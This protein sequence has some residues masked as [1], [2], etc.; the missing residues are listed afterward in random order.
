MKRQ[1]V[2][3]ILVTTVLLS[4]LVAFAQSPVETRNS[5][6]TTA[7]R[8]QRADYE[9]DRAAL[10]R[11][12]EELTPLRSLTNDPQLGSRVRYWQ[13]FALWRKAINGFNEPAAAP[14]ELEADLQQAVREFEEALR[15]DPAFVDARVGIISCAGYLLYLQREDPARVQELVSG[16]VQMLKDALAAAPEN[17]RVLW[18]QGP[19]L[20]YARPGLSKSEVAAR[21]ALALAAYEKGL[22]LA[23]RQRGTVKDPLEPSWGEPELLM[24][25]AWSH[26]NLA[27]PDVP[28]AEK[29]AAQAL[30]LVPYWHYVRDILMAQIRSAKEQP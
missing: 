24:N 1:A 9:G 21:Q 5:A 7:A 17:P 6:T 23:R 19:S 2:H 27:T 25:L 26:L 3:L 12:Y 4:A 29:Y 20:W 14:K 18:V 28:A 30:A 22:G 8:I 15:Q 13:G 16:L 10:Q 11:L